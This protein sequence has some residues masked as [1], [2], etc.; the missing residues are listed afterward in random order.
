MNCGLSLL[1]LRTSRLA[2][3][4][5]LIVNCRLPCPPTLT[6]PKSRLRFDG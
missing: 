2:V 3:P 1:I 4:E 6:L 5:L